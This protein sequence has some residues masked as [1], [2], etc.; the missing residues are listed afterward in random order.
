MSAHFDAKFFLLIA[1]MLASAG[2]G[3]TPQVAEPPVVE[4]PQPIERYTLANDNLSYTYT[5]QVGGRGTAFSVTGGRNLL[6]VDEAALAGLAPL[7]DLQ[8]DHIGYNGHIVWLGP[9]SEWWRKQDLDVERFESAAVWPPDPY[10]VFANTKRTV[11]SDNAVS[12]ESPPSPVTGMQVS[13]I[14]TLGPDVLAQKVIATNT[15]DDAV[16]WDIWFNTRVSADT[17]IVVPL[18]D[19]DTDLRVE[20]YGEGA[21]LVDENLKALGYFD[22]V[23]GQPMTGKAFIRPSAGWIAAFQ[24]GQMFVIEFDLQPR[25]QIHP[26]QGQVE[27]YLDYKPG[28]LAESLLELE[29]HAPYHELQPGA[30]MQAEERWRAW[31]YTGPNSPSAHLRALRERGY[32]AYEPKTGAAQ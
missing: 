15:R 11:L 27:I 23:R 17:Q 3:E 29:V 26:Q 30:A 13:K 32:V 12:L 19:F 7:A 10:T 22:F 6:Q 31:P 18:A 5:P 21:M 1:A 8:T 9:Q 25:E 16:G 28:N 24:A 4:A 14:L 20:S 2:C